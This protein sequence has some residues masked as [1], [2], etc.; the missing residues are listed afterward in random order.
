[1][2]SKTISVWTACGLAVVVVLAWGVGFG[3]EAGSV[4]LAQQDTWTTDA[5]RKQGIR[6]VETRNTS[7]SPAYPVQA[8]DLLFFTNS[9]TTF[10]AKNTIN[11]IIV[12]NAKTKKPIAVSEIENEWVQGFVSHGMGVS[13]DARYVYLPGQAPRSS[14]N[15][16][17]ILVLDGRTLKIR[18]IIASGG[19]RPHH[20]RNFQDWTGKQRV[21]VEDFNWTNNAPN[22]KG[23]FVLDPADNNKVLGGMT[24]GELRGNPYNGFVAPD[25]R[26]VYYSMPAPDHSIRVATE[27][28]LAKIDMQTWKVV[29]HIPMH[30]YPIWTVFSRDGRYAWVT[31]NGSHKILKLER[32]MAPGQL[33]KI[34]GEGPT[35]P[36][37]YGAALTMDEREVWVADKGEEVPAA[38]RKT[39]VTVVDAATMQLKRTIETGCR[40]N[41]HLMLSPDGDEMWAACNS[42]HEVVVVDTKTYQLKTRIPMPNQGDSH[43]GSFVSY[44]NGPNGLVAEVVSDTNGLHGSA[45]AAAEKGVRWAAGA[46]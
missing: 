8:G 43:G 24:P 42:S 10:G 21:L 14:K 26:Y 18:Q 30:R 27:G 36:G 46:R 19:E 13:P 25:G 38:Q 17:N 32:G 39:T 11:S 23:F 16:S 45:R 1:M 15:P 6:L 29:Q 33:D 37:P 40:T 34:V 3:D 20:V 44:T 41:D 4:A 35:G 7:G 28:W 22:G 31:Q 5:A 9:G 2:T 12:I